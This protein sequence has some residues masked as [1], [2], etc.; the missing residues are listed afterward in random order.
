[1]LP[2]GK[3]LKPVSGY[4]SFRIFRETGLHTRSASMLHTE[5]MS[6]VRRKAVA[7]FAVRSVCFGLYAG[8]STKENNASD[9]RI[10]YY[11]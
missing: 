3:A 7:T 8:L 4:L 10:R 1:M 9:K 6:Q 2:K 5:P 11:R